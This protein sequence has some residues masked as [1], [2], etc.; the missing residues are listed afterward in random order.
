M[1]PNENENRI[2]SNVIRLFISK[3]FTNGFMNGNNMFFFFFQVQ[4]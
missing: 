1:S 2:V 3:N 4:V